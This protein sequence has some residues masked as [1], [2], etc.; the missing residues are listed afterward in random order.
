[1]GARLPSEKSI[2][3]KLDRKHIADS[4]KAD[5]SIRGAAAY[6]AGYSGG[7]RF[8]DLLVGGGKVFHESFPKS[9]FLEQRV[10]QLAVG[11]M[12]LDDRVF[13][14]LLHHDPVLIAVIVECD[15]AQRLIILDACFC[16][17]N[18]ILSASLRFMPNFSFRVAM[19]SDTFRSVL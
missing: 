19:S 16:C 12:A 5:G 14:S 6:F 4:R 11:L 18:Q 10:E 8:A 2:L 1:V 13:R 3:G 15:D 9:G 17:S 7:V